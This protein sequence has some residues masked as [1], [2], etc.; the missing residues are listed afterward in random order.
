VTENEPDDRLATAESDDRPPAGI[1]ASRAVHHLAAEAGIRQFLDIGT[2]LP[3]ADNTHE[4]A[5]RT[6][7]Q[8]GSCTWTTTI[9]S[10]VVRTRARPTS[11]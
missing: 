9:A 7:P 3:S 8:S 6:A 5:Q 2:G 11:S 10:R 4:V 1:D